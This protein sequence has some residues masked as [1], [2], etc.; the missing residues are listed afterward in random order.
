M[1]ISMFR[2]LLNLHLTASII[3]RVSSILSTTWETNMH[4]SKDIYLAFGEKHSRLHFPS[5]LHLS[6]ALLHQLDI[7]SRGRELTIVEEGKNVE[8]PFMS[9]ASYLEYDAVILNLAQRIGANFQSHISYTSA[10]DDRICFTVFVKNKDSLR[11]FTRSLKT[12]ELFL[13]VPV[14]DILKVD[15]SL[16]HAIDWMSEQA[17]NVHKNTSRNLR[18]QSIEALSKHPILDDI[19]KGLPTELSI[20]FRPSWSSISQEKSSLNWF[21][22]LLQNDREN[23]RTLLERTKHWENF[24]WT[25]KKTFDESSGM[26]TQ[27][28]DSKSYHHL[29]D[30]ED[31]SH[32]YKQ[33]KN[34]PPHFDN[35]NKRIISENIPANSNQERNSPM[36]DKWEILYQNF[37]NLESNEYL[38]KK[39]SIKEI[40][41]EKCDYSNITIVHRKNNILLKLNSNFLQL[42]KNSASCLANI[43]ILISSDKGVSRIALSRPI[44]TLNNVARP[45]MQNGNVKDEPYSIAGLDGTGVVV[46]ISDTGI[47]ENSCYFKDPKGKILRSSPEFPHIDHNYRKVIL[48]VN[49][50]GS[51]GDTRA[52]HGSHVAGTV[53]GYSLG[54]GNQY[55]GMASGAKLAFFDIGA[56]NQDLIV[57][58]DL[59][60]YLFP[61][62]YLAGAR[63]HS[64]SWGGGYWYDAYCIEVDDYLYNNDDFLTFFAGGNNGGDG[65]NTILSPGLSKNSIAVAA[66][67]TTSIH[68]SD[69][70]FFSS[71]GPAPDGR[72]KPDITAPGYYISSANAEVEGSNKESCNVVM[73]AGTSMATP[74]SAGTAALLIQYFQDKNFWLSYCNPSYY[75]CLNGTFTPKGPTI[76]ALLIH[77][78]VGMST[79]QGMGNTV[80]RVI[81]KSRPDIFQGFGRVNLINILPLIH[82]TKNSYTLYIDQSVL[83]PLS[84]Y[85]YIVFVRSTLQPLR[86]T[87]SWFDPPNTE[88]AAKVLLHDLDLILI[89]PSGVTYNGNSQ[90]MNKDIR[91]ELNNVSKIHKIF[92][93]S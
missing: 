11:T 7:V 33:I 17:L 68:M 72:N 15:H 31:F 54:S 89:S 27:N 46:G 60:T 41:N 44:R 20:I 91:D 53:A 13:F 16:L 10:S 71:I 73:K 93:M 29:E 50:S 63:L 77:S 14:P 43:I 9:C 74:V 30:D 90:I 83:T 12:K 51:G 37:L 76:K 4:A 67:Y 84:E 28:S 35:G 82:Y 19:S 2:F 8:H 38:N 56:T 3:T 45:I 21:E 79:Y 24:I 64:N 25:R 52:G 65:Y 22:N 40:S 88:F 6:K 66:S 34:L 61:S 55:K 75:L 87:I 1:V 5:S 39:N 32:I 47:D 18:S 80:G 62:A 59:S 78:G 57:P 36:T 85:R 48:Y 86:A 69:I 23:S 42:T 92:Y 58:S 49:F 70:A 81:L 26:R